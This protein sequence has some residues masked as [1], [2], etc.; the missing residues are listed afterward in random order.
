MNNPT[1]DPDAHAALREALQRDAARVPEPPFDAVLHRATMRRIR[2]LA[3]PAS[4]RWNWATSLS[5]A[6]AVG[7]VCLLAFLCLRQNRVQTA[8]FA[9]IGLPRATVWAYQ[10]AA[11]GREDAFFEMLDRDAQTLLPPSPPVSSDTLD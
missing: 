7:A 4:A 6:T 3:D 10:R 8:S 9:R 1:P 5:A 11:N 2:A